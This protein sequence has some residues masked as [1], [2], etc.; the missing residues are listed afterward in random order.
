MQ[1]NT[2]A[3]K[4]RHDIIDCPGAWYGNQ[5]KAEW[6]GQGHVVIDPAKTLEALQWLKRRFLVSVR[7]VTEDKGLMIDLRIKPTTH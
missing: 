3:W 7:N 4:A 5:P 6:A 1:T 2:L